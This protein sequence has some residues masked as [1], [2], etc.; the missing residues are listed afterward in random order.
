M[1]ILTSDQLKDKFS[2][3]KRPNGDDF[4]DLIDT[5]INTGYTGNV[6]IGN[7][8]FSIS[9]GII[10]N[11]TVASDTTPGSESTTDESTVQESTTQ[12]APQSTKK[13]L[14]SILLVSGTGYDG[15]YCHEDK[16]FPDPNIIKVYVNNMT[17]NR[18]ISYKGDDGMFYWELVK[19]GWFGTLDSLKSNPGISSGIKSKGFKEFSD[20]TSLKGTW[21]EFFDEGGVA[22]SIR[23]VW[24]IN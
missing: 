1:P 20:L 6:T 12:S 2:D 16:I 21:R 11:I 14:S 5:C 15:T 4:A 13:Q 9:N 19:R 23:N 8:T 22:A 7:S 3:K 17:R 10:S 18:F 24:T